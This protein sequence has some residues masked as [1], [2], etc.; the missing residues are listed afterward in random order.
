MKNTLTIEEFKAETLRRFPGVVWQ[1]SKE[2]GGIEGVDTNWDGVDEEM[3]IVAEYY[4]PDETFF[5]CYLGKDGKP[6]PRNAEMWGSHRP[7]S[8][9][10]KSPGEIQGFSFIHQA[11]LRRERSVPCRV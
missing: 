11:L 1:D 9:I 3:K 2:H 7:R 8:R 5:I 4:K 6:E 10:R